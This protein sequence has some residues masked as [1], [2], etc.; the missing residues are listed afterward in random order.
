MKTI[1]VTGINGYLGSLLAKRYSKEYRVIG[2]EYGIDNLFRLKDE[3]F[4]VY[5][6]K[7]GVYDA[8]FE[9]HKVDCV[10]HTATFYGREQE[11]D[12]KMMYTNTYLPQ[13]LLEKLIKNGCTFFI[14]TDTVLDRY[15]SS[16][17]LTK[18]QFRDWL[19]FYTKL[20]EMKVANLQL[21]HFYGP[22]TAATNFI[23]LMTQKMLRNEEIIALTKAEQNRDFLFI[24]D[25]VQ[26]YDLILKNESKFSNYEDF[27]VGAGVNTNLK[28]ILEFI[29]KHTG[30]SSKLNFG[31]I[32]YR[33]N[34]LME[35]N[36]NITKLTKLGWN[37]QT[38]IDEGL[39][40]II[41]YEKKHI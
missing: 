20:G 11:S 16:Y 28:Y 3:N 27:N 9:K 38:S 8:I 24:D 40:K 14:N 33:L 30:S 34:E 6:S 32:P 31:A 41:N 17:A 23:T 1:L 35:S 12:S 2:L 25:L 5:N 26:V 22:G 13:I 10:I 18:K 37:T 15:T 39:L 29:K 36:N 4:E 21:E 7:G 19:Q